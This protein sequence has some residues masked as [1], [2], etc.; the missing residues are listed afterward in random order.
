MT[1]ARADAPV[2]GTGCDGEAAPASFAFGGEPPARRARSANHTT[3]PMSATPA[4]LPSTPPAM[5]P[6]LL[7]LADAGAPAVVLPGAFC[8]PPVFRSP[9]KRM[10]AVPGGPQDGCERVGGYKPCSGGR[11]GPPPPQ[12]P[13]LWVRVS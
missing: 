8:G 2:A 10:L 4:R 11:R 13:H 6:A 12:A 3:P 9:V 7:E 1:G 5:A